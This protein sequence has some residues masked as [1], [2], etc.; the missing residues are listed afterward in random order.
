[1]DE[2]HILAT[3][4]TADLNVQLAN[5]EAALRI[6]EIQV[7][8]AE[9]NHGVLRSLYGAGGIP[10]NDLRQAE[11]ALQS[12]VAFRRQAQAQVDATLI[13]LERS[14]IRAPIRGTITAVVAR[15][16]SVGMGLLF[17][18]EDTDN[19]RVMTSFRES[20]LGLVETGMGVTITSDATGSAEYAGIISRINPA[21]MAF[22]PIAEFEAEV[23]IT[24]KN[25]NL[26]I[27]ANARLDIIL[28]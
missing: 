28:Y 18:V 14:I 2:G 10:G 22:A 25:T 8:T 9:H 4:D 6:A 15:E 5:A 3:L 12:A 21:A 19:L 26:R 27:G 1:V 7:T 24:S 16:G 13:A 11:F 17:V 23:L 20:D